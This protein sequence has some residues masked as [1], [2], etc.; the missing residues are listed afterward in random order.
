VYYLAGHFFFTITNSSFRQGLR[1]VETNTVPGVDGVAESFEYATSQ[2][3][4][5]YVCS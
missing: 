5:L 1:H 4:I 3:R 2:I